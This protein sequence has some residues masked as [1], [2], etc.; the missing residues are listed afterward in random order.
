MPEELIALLY[1]IS[2]PSGTLLIS[3]IAYKIYLK[4]KEENEADY[5]IV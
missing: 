2:I 1:I 3:L 5:S 4:C